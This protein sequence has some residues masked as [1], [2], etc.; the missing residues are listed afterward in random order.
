LGKQHGMYGTPTY[1]SWSEM[2]CRCKNPKHSKCSKTYEN[3]SYCKEWE[4]F[5]NFLNDMGVRPE[6]TTL[7]RIDPNGN[8]EPSNCRWADKYLQANNKTTTKYFIYNG[9]N[10]TLSQISRK[11]G[12]SRSNLANKIYVKKMNITDAVNYLI[13]KRRDDLSLKEECFLKG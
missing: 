9:E 10:L 6:G 8:Y 4:D 3:I 1:K 7:D 13:S 11:Y 12:I 5:R 2:K